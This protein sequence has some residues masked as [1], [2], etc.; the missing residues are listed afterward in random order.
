MSPMRTGS[1]AG[2]ALVATSI[3][4]FAPVERQC[5]LM[6]LFVQAAQYVVRRLDVIFDQ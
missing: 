6:P 3:E 5:G 4:A 1:M 2:I